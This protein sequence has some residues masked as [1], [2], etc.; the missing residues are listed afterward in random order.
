MWF[1]IIY[2]GIN[3]IIVYMCVEVQKKRD[4]MILVKKGD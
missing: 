4:I 2:Y 3:I 1:Y